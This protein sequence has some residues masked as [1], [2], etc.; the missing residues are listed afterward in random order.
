MPH[1]PLSTPTPRQLHSTLGRADGRVYEAIY[2]EAR[3]SPL[4]KQQMVGWE[5]LRPVL[6]VDFIKE[7]HKWQ[8]H[9][10]A[11]KL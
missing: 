7:G 9:T 4:N 6:D 11:A 10:P 1:H 2:E 8:R 3:R 5:K